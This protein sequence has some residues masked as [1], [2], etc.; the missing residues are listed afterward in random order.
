MTRERAIQIIE[1]LGV[2]RDFVDNSTVDEIVS[3]VA[4]IDYGNGEFAT[5]SELA[6]LR[7]AVEYLQSH[8]D[9]EIYAGYNN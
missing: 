1:R 5:E 3:N 6:E 9:T 8:E 2:G 7:A 4:D